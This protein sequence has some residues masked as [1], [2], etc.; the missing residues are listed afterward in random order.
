MTFPMPKLET[1]CWQLPT[2]PPLLLAPLFLGCATGAVSSQWGAMPGPSIYELYPCCYCFPPSSICGT[3]TAS[4]QWGAILRQG[5]FHLCLCCS[6]WREWVCGGSADTICR[7]LVPAQLP[8]SWKLNQHEGAGS[9]EKW[10]QRSLAPAR[11]N[12]HLHC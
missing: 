5:S 6:W 9:W 2:L 8:A 10:Q 4:R 11:E 3:G 12:T 7:Y 1:G